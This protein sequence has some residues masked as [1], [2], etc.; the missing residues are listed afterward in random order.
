MKHTIIVSDTHL[1]TTPGGRRK[2][3]AFLRFLRELDPARVERL[4]LMGDIFDFWFEYH[5]VVFSGYFDVLCALAALRRRGVAL[6]FCVGNHDFWA[7]RFLQETVGMTVYK[8]PAVVTLHGKKVLLVH[9]DSL[10][11]KDV[12]YRIYKRVARFAPVVSLFRLLHPDWAMRL[13]QGVSH[14]SR[15]LSREKDPAQGEEA[16]F[17]RQFARETLAKGEVDVVICGH[18]HHPTIERFPTPGGEGVYVNAGDWLIHRTWVVWEGDTFT[19]KT[20]EPEDGE[21]NADF[22]S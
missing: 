5:Q 8:K 11:P 19:L 14:G 7:G 4:I 20:F 17:Q 18:S 21:E 15:S 13:A 1:S 22:S 12:G 2:M 3:A 6:D 10:N 9:G 16:R